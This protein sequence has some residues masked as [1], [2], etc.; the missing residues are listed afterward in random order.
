MAEEIVL[1]VAVNPDGTVKMVQNHKL[2]EPGRHG[3]VVDDGSLSASKF[4]EIGMDADSPANPFWRVQIR[5]DGNK[6]EVLQGHGHLKRG[7]RVVRDG[8][9]WTIEQVPQD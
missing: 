2:R 6:F 3:L 7:Y 4:R 9:G 1:I 8:F 5:V